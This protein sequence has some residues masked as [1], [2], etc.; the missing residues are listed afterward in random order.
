MN[1]VEPSASSS[2]ASGVTVLA[3]SFPP[4]LRLLPSVPAAAAL[5]AA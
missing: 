4:D 5:G 1:S 3:V 2:S